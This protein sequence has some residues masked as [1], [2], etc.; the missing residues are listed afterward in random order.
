[1]SNLCAAARS[2]EPSR[3]YGSGKRNACAGGDVN[4]SKPGL[5]ALRIAGRV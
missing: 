1:M 3:A 4:H 2:C 5:A